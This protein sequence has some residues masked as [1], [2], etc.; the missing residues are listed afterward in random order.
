MPQKITMTADTPPSISGA[1]LS[2]PDAI[3][4]AANCPA[5]LVSDFLA[6]ASGVQA[7]QLQQATWEID[8]QRWQGRRYDPRQQFEFPRVAYESASRVQPQGIITFTFAPAPSD[9]VWDWDATNSVCVVPQRVLVACLYQ[10]SSNI[11]G[12]RLGRLDE[13]HDGV[14]EAANS[15]LSEKR[16]PKVAGQDSGLSLCRAAWDLLRNYRLVSGRLV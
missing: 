12:A 3:S 1:Y 2:V 8:S 11:N 4:L 7:A 5:P 10:A 16:D 6:A 15:G 9:I 13:M 14:I